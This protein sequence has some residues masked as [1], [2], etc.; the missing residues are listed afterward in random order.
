VATGS[1][2]EGPSSALLD[3]GSH[4]CDLAEHVSGLRITAVLADLATVV[5]VRFR[6]SPA[7]KRQRVKVTTEDLASVLLRF[8]NGARGCLRVGQVLPGHK[9]DLQLEVN[10]RI[11]RCAGCRR[12]R[13][14][15]G[16]GVTRNPTR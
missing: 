8:D 14:N 11:A 2:Q 12:S 16:S 9:N 6:T 7:G 3:I 5:P 1:A 15:C 10:G 4:W 13:T